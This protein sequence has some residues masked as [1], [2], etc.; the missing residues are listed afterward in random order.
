MSRLT[1]FA[2]AFLAVLLTTLSCPAAEQP[3]V[4]TFTS[5]VD[6]VNIHV[7]V[8][9]KDK[10]FISGLHKEDFIVSDN[11]KR[12]PVA[13]IE[14]IKRGNEARPILRTPTT[15]TSTT[16]VGTQGEGPT[17]LIVVL[18][19]LHSTWEDQVAGREA[20]IN[21]VEATANSGVPVGFAV[22]NRSGL[23]EVH[24]FFDDPKLL[25][26][27]LK[28]S[29][30]QAYDPA[31]MT[32]VADVASPDPFHV[33]D[34]SAQERARQAATDATGMG[35]Q[36]SPE[37]LNSADVWGRTSVDP[38]PH[39]DEL[40]KKLF[41]MNEGEHLI[42]ALGTVDALRVMPLLFGTAPG[43][44]IMVFATGRL[45]LSWMWHPGSNIYMS[46]ETRWG[47]LYDVLRKLSDKGISVYPVDLRRLSPHFDSK[48]IAR[49]LSPE[50]L[51][52]LNTMADET[53]GKACKLTNDLRRCFVEAVDDASTYYSLGFYLNR[54]KRKPGWQ[55]VSIRV[56]KYG[57]AEVLS[58][59]GYFWQE[60]A[61][62][63]AGA[64]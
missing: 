15:A 8:R 44:K 48:N 4:P 40:L 26:A 18:D 24:A 41:E 19:L 39:A 47:N 58:R 53:G 49:P 11:G 1:T 6:L 34:V 43:R 9:D 2:V 21:A 32:T 56:N 20:L 45:T 30:G 54:A 33:A 17:R 28:R 5:A 55:K 38:V 64:K 42:D 51:M 46:T 36:S 22:L 29:L 14:E 25:I 13:M 31:S 7:V 16:A 60:Q 57:V 12:V 63:S 62:T 23:H 52:V 59:K 61:K 10:R 3:S 50:S 37:G 35:P 27:R